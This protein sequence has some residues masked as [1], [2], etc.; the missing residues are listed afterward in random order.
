MEKSVAIFQK[1]PPVTRIL[2]RTLPEP[3][4]FHEYTTFQRTMG[5]EWE[6]GWD[7]CLLH[8]VEFLKHEIL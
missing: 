8:A 1:Y 7:V 6:R 3:T 2:F 4:F 5:K